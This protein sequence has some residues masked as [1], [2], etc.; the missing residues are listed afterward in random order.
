MTKNDC[1]RYRVPNGNNAICKKNAFL[2]SILQW[3]LYTACLKK[4]PTCT[5]CYNFL[6]TQFDCDNFGTNAAEK[7]GNQNVVYFPTSSN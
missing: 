4:R 7:V 3:A 6:H 5:T 2:T 1:C